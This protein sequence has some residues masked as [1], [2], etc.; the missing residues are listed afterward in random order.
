[1]MPTFCA[2]LDVGVPEGLPGRSIVPALTG[3]GTPGRDVVSI[4]CNYWSRAL[5]GRRWKY[6]YEYVPNGN[7]SDATPPSHA[8]H[9]GGL[10]ELYDLQADPGE[11]INLAHDHDRRAVLTDWRACAKRI[12][13]DRL[14]RPLTDRRTVETARRW[15]DAI[16]DY[17]RA[18]PK[19]RD[20]RPSI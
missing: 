12:E 8:T 14:I 5:V 20:M 2:L 3:A 10:E 19:L 18:H 6:V 13:A 16:L 17:W 4:E 11:T 1:M 15:G 7:D 9:E